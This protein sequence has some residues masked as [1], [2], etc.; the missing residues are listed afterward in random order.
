MNLVLRCQMDGPIDP[1]SAVPAD[2]RRLGIVHIHPD[3]IISLDKESVQAHV[4][5]RE[6]VGVYSRLP[7]VHGNRSVAVNASKVKD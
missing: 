4:E 2:V 7:P 6:A 1:G 5:G 3:D